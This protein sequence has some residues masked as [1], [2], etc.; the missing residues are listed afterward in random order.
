MLP[1]A[2]CSVNWESRSTST[3]T[4]VL[5]MFFFGLVVPATIITYSYVSIVFVMKSVRW[6]IYIYIAYIFSN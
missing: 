4:Y 5:Y 2:S 6:N 1:H 3:T